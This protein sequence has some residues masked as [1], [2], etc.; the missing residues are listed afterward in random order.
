GKTVEP[1]EQVL[2]APL[3]DE[4]FGVALVDVGREQ[5]RDSVVE[6]FDRVYAELVGLLRD[7]AHLLAAL[8]EALVERRDLQLAKRRV[9]VVEWVVLL[10]VLQDGVDRR[11]ALG[12]LLCI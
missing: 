10:P 7:D 4:R 6:S 5:Q 2:P 3:G 1:L 8:F 9:V 11:G 12:G